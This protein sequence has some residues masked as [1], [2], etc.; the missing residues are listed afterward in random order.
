MAGAVAF[1]T[2]DDEDGTPV[3]DGFNYTLHAEA[4]EDWLRW[5]AKIKLPFDP[6]PMET[7]DSPSGRR[8]E[9]DRELGR[10]VK[11]PFPCVR[12]RGGIRPF[13]TISRASP[14]AVLEPAWR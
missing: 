7:P 1:A 12:G 11:L 3:P 4:D 8:A 5:A 6:A 13:G 9:E 2:P 14:S 10:P